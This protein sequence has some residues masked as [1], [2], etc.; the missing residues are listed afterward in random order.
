VSARRHRKLIIG[1]AIIVLALTGLVLT[2][3]RQSVVY[4][5]TPSELRAAPGGTAGK[6]YRVGGMVVPGSL[7]RDPATLRQDFLL[8]DGKATVPVRFRGI[9]PDLFGEGRGAVV[10]GTL[11]QD[12]TFQASTIMA[13]HSEEY[14]APHDGQP[15]YQELLKTFKGNDGA[16]P[17][18]AGKPG[19]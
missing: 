10:E 11:A 15:G 19:G 2:G 18:A 7:R 5:V 16:P 9:P 3:V 14:K 4:F 17:S 12:G 1:G 6:A 13:K 8:S